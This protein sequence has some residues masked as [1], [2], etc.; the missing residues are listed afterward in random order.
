MNRHSMK[1]NYM[2]RACG[3]D[4]LGSRPVKAAETDKAD[5]TAE[6]LSGHLHHRFGRSVADSPLYRATSIFPEIHF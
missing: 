3:K 5:G 6:V 1:A 2:S 4:I